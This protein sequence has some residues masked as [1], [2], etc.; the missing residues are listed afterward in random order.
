MHGAFQSDERGIS[1]QIIERS[2]PCGQPIA[3]QWQHDRACAATRYA[4]FVLER[5]YKSP[6]SLTKF[7]VCVSRVLVCIQC[8]PSRV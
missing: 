4:M 6:L 3:P 5:E 2:G 1:P 7:S 8:I